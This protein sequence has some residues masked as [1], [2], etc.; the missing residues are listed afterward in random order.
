VRIHYLKSTV[1][2]TRLSYKFFTK[3]LARDNRIA[4]SS[5]CVSKAIV[6]GTRDGVCAIKPAEIW[7][8][9]EELAFDA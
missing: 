8:G 3:W 5:R 7:G 2:R 9:E 4:T 1:K 6:F